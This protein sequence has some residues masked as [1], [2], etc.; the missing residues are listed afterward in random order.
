[1]KIH[2]NSVCTRKH[3]HQTSNGV[4][5]DN[6]M[7]ETPTTKL[8]PGVDGGLGEENRPQIRRKDGVRKVT[9]WN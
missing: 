2:F 1:M 6:S 9:E 8:N 3:Q 7:S 5:S 4:S